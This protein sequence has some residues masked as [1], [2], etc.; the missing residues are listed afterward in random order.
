MIARFWNFLGGIYEML[1]AGWICRF[2]F[3]GSYWT[4][5]TNTAFPDPSAPKGRLARGRLA[6]A[7]FMWVHR[8]RNGQ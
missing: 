5:R 4:W 3:K 6:I 8:I 2:R 1:R 7:Y